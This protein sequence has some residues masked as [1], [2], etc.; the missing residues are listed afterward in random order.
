MKRA[1]LYIHIPF[2][3]A[4]CNY[5]DFYS[6]ADHIEQLPEYIDA[7][8][9]ELVNTDINT[10]EWA[11]D[12]LFFGGGTPSLLSPHDLRQILDVVRKRFHIE[13]LPEITLEANPGE[14]P[15]SKLVKFWE[16]GINRLSIGAQSFNKNALKFLTRIHSTEDIL[17]TF[18][19]ARNT[20]FE[21]INCD[22]IYN[23]PGQSVDDWKKD[24]EK[25][26]ALSPE[27]ISA[28]SLIVEKGTPLFNEVQTGR[29]HMPSESVSTRMIRWTNEF[30]NDRGYQQYEISNYALQGFECKHNIHYWK[31]DSYLGF[32]PSAHS[33]DGKKRWSNFSDL[34]KYI[35]LIRN[36]RSPVQHTLVLTSLALANEIIGF[37]IRMNAGVLLNQLPIRF[38]TALSQKVEFLGPEWAGMVIQENDRIRLSEQG[39]LFADALA[40]E[41][42]LD[43]DDQ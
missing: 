17:K 28:Y 30:L 32:G 3:K 43:H 9:R 1:G 8:I 16:A 11:I 33:F 21:N 35:R 15:R 23:I 39:M 37:G 20:G 25:V 36:N 40:V 22:M 13:G 38:R 19:S 18:E 4:K 7:L 34:D 10:S 14:A 29:V 27:H 24:L 2:C 41:F 12:T 5:C 26:V 31:I 6:I 42:M